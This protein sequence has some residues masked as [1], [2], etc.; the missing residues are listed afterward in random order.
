MKLNEKKAL[1][2]NESLVKRAFP[3]KV[4]GRGEEENSKDKCFKLCR[5][6][7]KNFTTDVFVSICNSLIVQVISE[8]EFLK[9][10]TNG[11]KG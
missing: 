9:R 7:M 10:A 5:F 8:A 6:H 2:K 11:E 1:C 4:D 3:L